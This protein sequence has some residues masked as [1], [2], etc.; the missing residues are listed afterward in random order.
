M[1]I[2]HRFILFGFLVLIPIT[3]KSEKWEILRGINDFASN[4][5]LKETFNFSNGDT[6]FAY[7]TYNSAE[8]PSVTECRL[9]KYIDKEWTGYD[10][11]SEISSNTT[12]TALISF[13]N[14]SEF[15]INTIDLDK[16]NNM[17]INCKIY[18]QLYSTFS[19]SCLLKKTAE[20]ITKY[21]KF[22][23]ADSNRYEAINEIAKVQFD[24]FNTPYIICY[25]V[26][27]K[28]SLN[29]KTF[30]NNIL[31]IEDDT[32][33][34]VMSLPLVS[35]LC[36]E[37]SVFRFDSKNN[38]WLANISSLYY[39][40]QDTLVKR[41]G[42]GYDDN[43]LPRDSNG[44][45]NVGRFA[46]IFVNSMDQLTAVASSDAIY[47]FS[48]NAWSLDTTAS[49]FIRSV[50]F[51]SSMM[52]NAD[53]VQMDKYNNLWIAPFALPFLMQRDAGGKWTYHITPYMDYYNP[54]GASFAQIRLLDNGKI[55]LSETAYRDG[56][57]YTI[58]EN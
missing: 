26:L 20:G 3:A 55:W 34:L 44:L 42:I 33:K 18:T 51:V 30:I 39:F 12:D 47:T 48:N 6:L 54:I 23:R 53:R 28:D 25:S 38:F 35:S 5:D 50:N 14:H 15:R 21:D 9:W 31:K 45:L 22:Y 37:S 56:L 46:N 4:P 8:N 19:I 17:W 52:L 16:D 40:A 36:D 10:L 11:R 29:K 7:S 27:G 13:L 24:N 58:K 2:L 41:Y 57:I 49:A 43:D 1:K 32:L